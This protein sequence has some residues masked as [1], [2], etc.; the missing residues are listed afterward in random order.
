[1]STAAQRRGQLGVQ[2]GQRVVLVIP[3]RESSSPQRLA[4][5]LDGIRQQGWVVASV[6][7]P[8]RHLDALRMVVAGL[9]DVVVAVNHTD[10]P[11][12]KFASDLGKRRYEKTARTE[13][14]PRPD[15]EPAPTDVAQDESP[16]H[17]RPQL[18]HVDPEADVEA[19]TVAPSVPAQRRRAAD[20]RSG[21]AT[22]RR[23]R[24]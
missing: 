18:L 23:R 14:L 3:R 10:L 16:R 20:R 11:S 7:D 12:L 15:L 6:V 1:V 21:A 19:E 13:R 9:A 5:A 22:R 17:R 4:A 8:E 2:R 24:A